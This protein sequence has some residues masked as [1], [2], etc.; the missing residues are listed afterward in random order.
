MT[1][2]QV[3]FMGTLRWMTRSRKTRRI[4]GFFMMAGIVPAVAQHNTL[5]NDKMLSSKLRCGATDSG[6]TGKDL[7]FTWPSAKGEI[8]PFCVAGKDSTFTFTT[9]SASNDD[10]PPFIDIY[11]FPAEGWRGR[12]ETAQR[13]RG[14]TGE[15]RARKFSLKE[16]C[17]SLLVV[18]VQ[19]MSAGPYTLTTECSEHAKMLAPVLEVAMPTPVFNHFP[20]RL[21]SPTSAALP[22]SAACP[23]SALRARCVTSLCHSRLLRC[24]AL[25]LPGV[26]STLS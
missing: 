24:R 18:A 10:A 20:L 9:T 4:V 12:E 3:I 23:S 22:A 15:K 19:S 6:D 11:G 1:A 26:Q 16:G 13:N 2:F 14:D 17:H 7:N 25:R 8:W 21:P 5:P